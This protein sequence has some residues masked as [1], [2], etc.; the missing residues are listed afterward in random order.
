[1]HHLSLRHTFPPLT[2]SSRSR[3]IA[4][5]V[6]L[7]EERVDLWRTLASAG[8]RAFKGRFRAGGDATDYNVVLR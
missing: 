4:G 7:T 8:V 6:F 1:M 3:R 5:V 2:D